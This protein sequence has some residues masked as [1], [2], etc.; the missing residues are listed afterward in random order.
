MNYSY[1]PQQQAFQYSPEQVEDCRRQRISAVRRRFNISLG[2]QIVFTAIFAALLG[3]YI[4]R[5]RE[6]SDSY[7][8]RDGWFRWYIGL[9]IALLV[10]DV[11]S[12]A[13]TFWQRQQKLRW[14]K[15]PSTPHNLIMDGSVTKVIVVQQ[16]A[17]GQQTYAPQPA[18]GQ[19]YAQQPGAP[20]YPQNTAGAYP[21]AHYGQPR[22]ATNAADNHPTS[23]G[24][25]NPDKNNGYLE[26][27]IY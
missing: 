3:Y 21:S 24:A 6:Y 25:Q 7:P 14:L 12:I 11:L 17:Y 16:P 22:S 1:P 4:H 23:P 8:Y 27:S 19:Q 18:Y 5:E 26:R 9:L 10:L 20:A 2:I 13:Y 15:D